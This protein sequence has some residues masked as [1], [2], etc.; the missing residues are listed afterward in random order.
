MAG[1]NT[2]VTR[3]TVPG[4]IIGPNGEVTATGGQF[5]YPYAVPAVT[6]EP[7]SPATTAPGSF[8]GIAAT[9]G[10]QGYWLARVRRSVSPHGTAADYGSMAGQAAGR[11]DR[12]HRG[13][14]RRQ[15]LLAGGGRRWHLQLSA[16]PASTARWAGSHLNAPVVDMT[17]TAD[18]RGYWLVAADGGIF[19]FGDAGLPRLDGRACT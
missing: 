16:T 8:V 19:A 18:G 17:P 7:A 12:P 4:Q 13:H 10:D 5:P 1:V 3:S 2:G 11:P 9:N 15:G 6:G 14:S